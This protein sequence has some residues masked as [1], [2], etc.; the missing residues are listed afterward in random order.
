MWYACGL[1]HE[2][3]FEVTPS[4]GTRWRWPDLSCGWVVI[5]VVV[6]V[7][8]VVVVEGVIVVVVVVVVEVVE[9]RLLWS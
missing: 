8:I 3:T 1:P 2:L 4:T 6:G 7:V 9:L 5:V